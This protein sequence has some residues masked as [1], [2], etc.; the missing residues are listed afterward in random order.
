MNDRV[1]IP[2]ELLARLMAAIETPDDLSETDTTELLEDA[3][4]YVSE[5]C[6]W[7]SPSG[8]F[9]CVKP[10]GHTGNCHTVRTR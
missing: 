6:G 1:S 10:K 2:T 8:T 7:T 9:V 5:R 3:D 4:A